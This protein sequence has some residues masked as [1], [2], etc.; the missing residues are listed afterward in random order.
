M[1]KSIAWK[2]AVRLRKSSGRLSQ[3][4]RRAI[5]VLLEFES[6]ESEKWVRQNEYDKPS[7]GTH[8]TFLVAKACAIVD[9]FLVVPEYVF[10]TR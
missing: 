1:S 2:W 6:W 8:H 3:F 7:P 4:V 9:G 10:P 5:E